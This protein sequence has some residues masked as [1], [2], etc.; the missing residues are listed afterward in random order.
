MIFYLGCADGEI[1]ALDKIN[2]YFSD[3]IFIN[4]Y[5]F[6]YSYSDGSGLLDEVGVSTKVPVLKDL[7][8]L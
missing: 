2:I 7:Q 8:I 1:F 5:H 4:I 6:K 3:I